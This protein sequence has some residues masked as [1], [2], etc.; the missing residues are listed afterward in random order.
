[1][2]NEK[3]NNE[4]LSG[5]SD[6]DLLKRSSVGKE[7]QR[8]LCAIALSPFSKARDVGGKTSRSG[9]RRVHKAEKGSRQSD[10]H[11][12]VNS[13]S[14]R[15]SRR[16]VPRRSVLY[17]DSDVTLPQT[18]SCQHVPLGR[19]SCKVHGRFSVLPR[20]APSPPP[21]GSPHNFVAIDCFAEA[22]TRCGG[23][24]SGSSD[25]CQPGRTLLDEVRAPGLQS[26]LELFHIH[27]R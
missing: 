21:A 15:P 26:P 22:S 8:F 5:V 18:L 6:A 23:D 13:R 14:D 12:Y 4:V 17:S 11:I 7:V 25:T 10:S 16:V 2:P 27:T 24:N 3:T 9:I 19:G 1:M 20:S